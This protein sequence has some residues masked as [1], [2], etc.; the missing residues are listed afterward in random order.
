MKKLQVH[1]IQGVFAIFN[2]ESLLFP[3]VNEK[4]KV[5]N[6]QNS[7]FACCLLWVWNLVSHTVGRT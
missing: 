1:Y 5:C 4:Q 3:T 7:N 6:I 2:A